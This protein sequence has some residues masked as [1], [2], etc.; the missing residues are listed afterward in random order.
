ML[1]SAWVA[2]WALWQ[3]SCHTTVLLLCSNALV[4]Q[5]G[6]GAVEAQESERCTTVA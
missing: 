4:F 5:P 2:A 6:T 3:H 1:M